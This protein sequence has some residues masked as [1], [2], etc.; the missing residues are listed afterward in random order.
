GFV[1]HADGR[2]LAYGALAA[3]AVNAKPAAVVLKAP[4]DFKLIGRAQ[5]RRDSP[6]KV[7]GSA[8][9]GIDVRPPG[10]VYAAVCMA[11]T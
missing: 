4:R 9:F 1:I 8:V 7:N 6:S 2:R 3:A 5:P 11:P 10:M